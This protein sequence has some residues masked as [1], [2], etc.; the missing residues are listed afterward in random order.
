VA[1][2]VKNDLLLAKC[3]KMLGLMYA[4]TGNFPAAMAALTRALPAARGAHDWEQQSGIF[5]NW[6]LAHQYAG[7]FS[8]AIPCYERAVEVADP[9]ATTNL[10][11]AIPLVNTAV[12]SL[13][14]RDFPRGLAAA[15]RAIELLAEP[16]DDSERM[17]R[18]T[19]EFAY[20]RL[21]LEVRNVPLALERARLARMHGKGA[22]TL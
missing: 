6:G 9:A 7:Q 2:R 3:L 17:T 15:E 14:L 4:E 19:I 10:T 21:L 18:A 13:Y 22:G 11:Q 20:T 5:A 1:E 16:S 8:M 12:A